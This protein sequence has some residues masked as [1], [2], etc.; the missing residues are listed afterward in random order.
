MIQAIRR[1]QI[2]NMASLLLLS[3]GVPMI[4]AGDEFGRTQKG[5]NNGYCQD[6]EISW[7]DWELTEKNSGLLRFFRR[8]IQF[9][10]EHLALRR[11]TFFEDD[12]SKE[13]KIQWY[14]AILNPP[15]WTG[16]LKSLAFH[17][18]PVDQDNDIYVISNSSKKRLRFHI[19]HL[20]DPKRWYL[21][22]DTNRLEPEDIFEKGE[23]VL[24][25]NQDYY[26]TEGQ[27]TVLLIGK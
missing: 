18:L 12:R 9:R 19:P 13:M 3:Q 24:L 26:S 6:N 23:E 10:K 4:L 21:V 20:S 2:K 1:K 14:D 17:L 15:N 7:V 25:I 16:K 11:N 5:N 8:L 27:S 22:M